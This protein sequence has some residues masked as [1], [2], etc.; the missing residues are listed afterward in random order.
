MSYVVGHVF[1]RPLTSRSSQLNVR[2]FLSS[3]TQGLMLGY[4]NL[5]LTYAHACILPTLFRFAQYSVL[6]DQDTG[7]CKSLFFHPPHV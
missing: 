5:L 4:A 6:Q 3:F 1:P 2:P 7:F